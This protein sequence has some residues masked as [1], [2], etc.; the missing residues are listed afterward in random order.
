MCFR[1]AELNLNKCPQCGKVN[2]PTAKEC[3]QCGAALTMNDLYAD[4]GSLAE[5]PAAPAAPAAPG[6]P[7]PPPTPKA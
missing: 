6:A 2:K 1:P 4:K 7:V 5:A 3:S